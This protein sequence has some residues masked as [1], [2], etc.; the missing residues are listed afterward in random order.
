MSLINDAL[1]QAKAARPATATTADGPALRPAF[2]PRRSHD[3]NNFLLPALTVVILALG[4]LLLWQW[5]RSAHGETTVRARTIEPAQPAPPTAVVA[6]APV[7]VP[8]T[9]VSTPPPPVT[10]APQP[11]VAAPV[12]QPAS[13]NPQPVVAA[14]VQPVV[15]PPPA[16]KL[17]GI[18]FRAKKPSAVING[19]TLFIGDRV[20]TAHLVAITQE[21][22]TILTADGEKK[23]LELP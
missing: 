22:A 10:P 1:K 2:S 11:A 9:V 20:G 12:Q 17:Q 6:P 18:F 14:P 5:T 16:F 8:Q 21:S 7:S 15:P 4:S 3:G 23:L 19:K 13:S